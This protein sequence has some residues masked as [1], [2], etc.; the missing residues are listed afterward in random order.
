MIAPLEHEA[1]MQN[2]LGWKR[3]V[4]TAL[5][6]VAYCWHMAGQAVG[7]TGHI[8]HLEDLLQL[9]PCCYFPLTVTTM[10]A[11]RHVHPAASKPRMKFP[12]LLSNTMLP[13]VFF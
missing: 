3:H 12:L 5:R 1:R 9:R 4:D 8:G 6:D 10:L 2:R 13:K 11:G 7:W